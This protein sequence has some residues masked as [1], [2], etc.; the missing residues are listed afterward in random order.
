M[1][2]LAGLVRSH[3]NS[4]SSSR[5]P[6]GQDSKG[7][8]EPTSPASLVSTAGS[9]HAPTSHASPAQS[10]RSSL[11]PGS[12]TQAKYKPFQVLIR[13]TR[14]DL[15]RLK[16]VWDA[17]A[18]VRFLADAW[19]RSWFLELD[20]DDAIDRAHK[21]TRFVSFGTVLKSA[22]FLKQ[23]MDPQGFRV[24]IFCSFSL[25]AVSGVRACPSWPRSCRAS[26]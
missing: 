7:F 10:P 18:R 11:S 2:G 21:L 3:G 15:A 4:R 24:F 22:P 1:G 8:V 16:Q 25:L 19:R 12:H 6:S 17:V 23:S 14:G 9:L 20:L 13:D 26:W 5:S